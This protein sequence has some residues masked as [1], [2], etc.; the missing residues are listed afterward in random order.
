MPIG[1]AP[2][3][4]SRPPNHSTATLDRLRMSISAG[5]ASAK[6]RLARSAVAVRSALASRKRCCSAP[7]LMNAR[8]TRTPVICSRSTWLIRSSLTCM[9]RNSGT[10]STTMTPITT[11]IS[12]IATASSGDSAEPSLIAMNTP[13]THITGAMTISVSAICRNIWI[14]WTSLVLRVI[15][16]G[17]PNLFSSAAAN[18]CTR[19]KTSART[20]AP[21]LIDTRDARYTPTA[22]MTPMA[23]A[24]PSITAPVRQ[25]YA[26]SPRTTPLLM[27]SALRLGRYRLPA[28]CAAS[29]TTMTAT[30]PRYGARWRRSSA[31]STGAPRLGERSHGAR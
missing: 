9:D 17:V 15:S 10:T 31:V 14:C 29:S 1:I 7:V 25:M 27:M 30:W 12:G 20:S 23:S 5:S 11:P 2:S 3:L 16:D 21:T 13:P 22:A 26:V 8:I 19:S 18:P 6:M 28:A 4:T 24:I